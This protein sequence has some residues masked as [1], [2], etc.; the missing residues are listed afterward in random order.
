[1][2]DGMGHRRQAGARQPEGHGPGDLGLPSNAIEAQGARV[3]GG[4]HGGGQR[5]AWKGF[6]GLARGLGSVL[7]VLGAIAGM[8]KRVF[9]RELKPG[10]V[11]ER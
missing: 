4:V 11:L 8:G 2:Q 5:S 10:S 7:Q 1:M 3:R 6:A 9:S